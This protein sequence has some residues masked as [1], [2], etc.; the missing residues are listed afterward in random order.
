MTKYEKLNTLWKREEQRGKN[1]G[2]VIEG[3]YAKEEFSMIDQWEVTEKIDGMNIRIMIGPAGLSGKHAHYVVGGRTDKA[4]LP[5]PL[6]TNLEKIFNNID[7]AEIFDLSKA[8]DVTIYGEGYGAKI[9]KGGGKY[10]EDDQGFIV[11]DINID[12]IWLERELVMEFCEKM[13]LDVVPSFGIMT[14]A[15]IVDYVKAH[16]NSTFGDFKMEGV[17]CRSKPL[18]LDR[19]GRRIAFKLKVRDF[20]LEE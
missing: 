20:K 14:K 7:L 16:K 15:E 6:K 9:Q 12:G 5:E 18:L 1:I 3:D 10:L 2:K 8:D 13:G 19:M 4:V 11:F 17:V